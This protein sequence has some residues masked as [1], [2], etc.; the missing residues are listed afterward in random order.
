MILFNFTRA[1]RRLRARPASG[2][3]LISSVLILCVLGNAWAFYHFDRAYHDPLSFGDA[4]WYSVISITTIGYGDFY[5]QSTPARISTVFFIVLVGLS[6]FSIFF[7]MVIDVAADR[8]ARAKKGLG[9]VVTKNHILIVN[10][11][12]ETRVRQIIDEIYAEAGTPPEI[13]IVADNI[14][15]LPFHNPNI[16]F[17]RGSTHDSSTYQRARINDAR[18]AILLSRDYSDANSDALVAAAVSV[19]DKLEPDLQIVAECLDQRHRS[20]FEAVRCDAIVPGLQI[21]GN[22]LV[23]EAHDPGVSLM[24]EVITSNQRGSTVYSTRA[25]NPLA[26]TYREL[27]KTL[28]DHDVN[29]LAFNRDN[30]SI[31][32]FADHRPQTGD[33]LIYIARNRHTWPQLTPNP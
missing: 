5:A 8:L 13:V 1:A 6:A 25:D 15:E 14:D 7:G 2:F 21:A 16:I 11:P 9:S 27:A 19:I 29:M 31:T 20:L 24:I 17:V 10:F 22:L 32:D 12:S 28:L 4:L 30:D 33:T 3:S 26:T 23:Q 18:M